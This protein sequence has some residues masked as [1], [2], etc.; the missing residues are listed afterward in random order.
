[1]S[2]SDRWSAR[3]ESSARP[4]LSDKGR[5]ANKAKDF[6]RIHGGGSRLSA[7]RLAG[8]ADELSERDRSLL[9]ALAR[10][11]VASGSQ[12][13]RLCFRKIAVSARGRVRRRVL[14]RLVGLG[15]MVT[16]ERRVGGVRAGSAGL[17]YGL[18]GAGWRLVDQLSR[19]DDASRRRTRETPGTLFLA[20]ALGHL[21][22]LCRRR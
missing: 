8:L 16:L 12:L 19:S 9:L 6:S 3:V 13:E 11:R 21:R 22:D 1:M 14:G 20:H 4:S 10:L 15:L 7:R 18:S 2:R 5:R 17:V